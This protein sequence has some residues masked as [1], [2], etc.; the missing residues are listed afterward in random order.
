MVVNLKKAEDTSFWSSFF[1][2]WLPTLLLLGFFFLFLRNL[3]SG[4][5]KAMSFGKNRAKMLTEAQNKHSFAD[6]ASDV[7]EAVLVLSFS[8]HLGSILPKTHCLAAA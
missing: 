5:G 2:S 7:C 4:S 6:V 3:Q 1:I 8:K